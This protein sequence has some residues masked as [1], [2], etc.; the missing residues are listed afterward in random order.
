MKRRWVLVSAPLSSLRRAAFWWAAGLSALIAVTVAFWPAFR[1]SSGISDAIGQLPA[2][3]IQAFGLQ[4]FGTPAGFLR[5][6]LYEFFV[7]L[8]LAAAAVA[9]VN[10][11]TAAD[12]ASGR[13]ELFVSQPVE[14]GDLYLGR[15]VASLIALAAIV[16]VLLLVQVAADSAVGLDIAVSY[17]ASTIL[18][19]G[20]IAALFGALAFAVASAK[21]RPS[22][23]LAVGIGAAVAAYLVAALFPLTDL[24]EPWHHLSPWD[25]AFGGDPL[26]QATEI[27][28]YV[29]LVLPTVAFAAIGT[30]AVRRR[31]ISA[32]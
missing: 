16:V 10:G 5:G 19:S 3:V 2:S 28:R 11:Q 14:R 15:A 26:V 30:V 20:M 17:V 1:G 27:W 18:L 21:A 9:F 22:L 12:E 31:D 23:V 8:L 32:A 24:L 6:N 25:W 4:D 29:A 7:P 13:I